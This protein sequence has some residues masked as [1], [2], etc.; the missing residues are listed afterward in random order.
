MKDDPK[1]WLFR[2]FNSP[3]FDTW[4]TI[5]YLYRYPNNG[6]QYYL[7]RKLK[8]LP[9][10]KRDYFEKCLPHLVHIM[11]SNSTKTKDLST[12]SCNSCG[13]TDSYSLS[14]FE[15]DDCFSKLVYKYDNP[16]N[17]TTETSRTND[18]VCNV[19]YNEPNNRVSLNSASNS[20][21]CCSISDICNNNVLFDDNIL[22]NKPKYCINCDFIYDYKYS[23]SLYDLLKDG[24]IEVYFMVKGASDEY[25]FICEVLC[26]EILQ[27]G[28]AL[29]YYDTK[30]LNKNIDSNLSNSVV[31]ESST[32]ENN[33]Y[34]KYASSFKDKN[35]RY[36]SSR[37]MKRSYSTDNY[38]ETAISQDTEINSIIY[39]NSL[40][41]L[42]N[43]AT[44]PCSETCSVKSDNTYLSSLFI[45]K[46]RSRPSSNNS[47]INAMVSDNAK[48]TEHIPDIDVSTNKCNLKKLTNER[49]T[50]NNFGSYKFED[51]RVNNNDIVCGID[52][53]NIKTNTTIS[54]QINNM[55]NISN[56]NNTN[57]INSINNINM[58]IKSVDYLRYYKNDLINILDKDDTKKTKLPIYCSY[59]LLTEPK[60]PSLP[61]K[62][63]SI[64]GIFTFFTRVVSGFFFDTTEL[65]N[66]ENIF[67]VPLYRKTAN[68]IFT[69]LPRDKNVESCKCDIVKDNNK[70]EFL[71]STQSSVNADSFNDNYFILKDDDNDLENRE[72]YY[73][74]KSIFDSNTSK[75]TLFNDISINNKSKKIQ[76]CN[77][78]NVNDIYL[79][80]SKVNICNDIDI[81]NDKFS[82][83]NV[84][85]DTE[86]NDVLNI[87][88]VANKDNKLKDFDSNNFSTDIIPTNNILPINETILDSNIKSNM[89]TSTFKGNQINELE[90]F[91]TPNKKSTKQGIDQQSKKCNQNIKS[92]PNN[93]KSHSSKKKIVKSKLIVIKDEGSSC[94][95][96]SSSTTNKNHE[97][98]KKSKYSMKYL[99]QGFIGS[100]NIKSSEN[101]SNFN[102]N[103][104]NNTNE[105]SDSTDNNAVLCSID[106]NSNPCINNDDSI[107][108]NNDNIDDNTVFN[109]ID[110][111]MIDGNLDNKKL[112][113]Y[114]NYKKSESNIDKNKI[115]TNIIIDNINDNGIGKKIDL[116]E[117]SRTDEFGLKSNIKVP[118]LSIS[119]IECNTDTPSIN[120]ISDI[121]C[122]KDDKDMSNNNKPVLIIKSTSVIQKPTDVKNET[123]DGVNTEFGNT[124]KND[125]NIK[126]TKLDNNIN[127]NTSNIN[128]NVTD[129]FN[130]Q[131]VDGNYENSKKVVTFSSDI[132]RFYPNVIEIEDSY[133]ILDENNKIIEPSDK[134]SLNSVDSKNNNITEVNT[135]SIESNKTND[136]SLDIE[137][138]EEMHNFKNNID[139]KII[140]EH[141]QPMECIEAKVYVENINNNIS[142]RKN[143]I[144]KFCNKECAMNISHNKICSD[145]NRSINDNIKENCNESNIDNV[146]IDNSND[147][148]IKDNK[149]INTN[150]I[151]DD[152]N[153]NNTGN[154]KKSS[155]N[156]YIRNTKEIEPENTKNNCSH[157]SKNTDSNNR[158]NKEHVN[159]HTNLKKNKKNYIQ[160]TDIIDKNNNADL[161]AGKIAL[162]IHSKNLI[163]TSE[164]NNRDINN[165]ST[166]NLM[167]SYIPISSVDEKNN[168]NV[169]DN[170]LLDSRSATDSIELSEENKVSISSINENKKIM[171]K[172]DDN[173]KLIIEN[174]ININ[175]IP[176]IDDINN[177]KF[178]SIIEKDNMKP[179]IILSKLEN[180][181]QTE[182]QKINKID[183]DSNIDSNLNLNNESQKLK[184]KTFVIENSDLSVNV[185]KK[186]QP[187]IIIEQFKNTQIPSFTKTHVDV[188]S[189]NHLKTRQKTH[190]KN[191]KMLYLNP[192]GDRKNYRSNKSSLLFR[193][194]L[195]KSSFK[196][197]LPSVLFLEELVTICKRLKTL[198]RPLRQRGL[199]IEIDLLN[200]NIQNSI[201]PIDIP[202]SQSTVVNIVKEYSAILDSA[203]N[204]P[205][206][207]VFETYDKNQICNTCKSKYYSNDIRNVKYI[208]NNIRDTGEYDNMTS[209]NCQNNNLNK[210]NNNAETNKI[211]NNLFN[212]EDPNQYNNIYLDHTCFRK[213]KKQ[214]SEIDNEF[215]LKNSPQNKEKD[216]I[217]TNFKNAAF[218]LH[219]LYSL[220]KDSTL[221]QNEVNAIKER[222]LNTLNQEKSQ[223]NRPNLTWPQKKELIRYNSIYKNYK[224]YKIIPAIIKRGNDLRQEILALQILNE[225]KSIFAEEDL[226]IKLFTYK[227]ILITNKSAFIECIENVES[228][229]TIKKKHT[230]IE[231]FKKV[232]AK[233]V[234]YDNGIDNFLCSL[235]GY[236]LAT[237]LLQIKDRHNG[238]ILIKDDG[239]LIHVDFG[240]ILGTHPG[241]YNV[242]RAPFKMSTEYLEIL[243]SKMDIFKS[244]F[245]E[246]FMA[247]RRNSDRLCRIIE[248]VS[249]NGYVSKKNIQAF[250]ERLKMDMGDGDVERYVEG[251][252]GWSINS[253]GTGLYDSYQ[254]FSHGYLK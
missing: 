235:V 23:F 232:I 169:L 48:S 137:N 84:C 4:L 86:N 97:N 39:K 92:K 252:I 68:T 119:T 43:Q 198:P 132:I 63:L 6:I 5:S 57:N 29:K 202:L 187:N 158:N 131:S 64:Q 15:T 77:K 72:S 34:D 236:S 35:D 22:A 160:N 122:N 49:E 171:L 69:S 93:N 20:N 44:N 181:Q 19:Y 241:F 244:T 249:V 151:K 126:N 75:I 65:V 90:E 76:M 176:N 190:E 91:L 128:Q 196:S 222:I 47:L 117:K 36:G 52:K 253:I 219:K 114:K 195:F 27:R 88:S 62:C 197:I 179:K 120:K 141:K 165:N 245:I 30:M 240:F 156:I 55:K 189:K 221:A 16:F 107:I 136:N 146:N 121:S 157:N 33:N 161:T 87:N 199:E 242:E 159:T 166:E 133:S 216:I 41:Y 100:K 96:N 163:I 224:G 226:H 81:N 85:N 186:N 98:K 178:L 104:I 206:Y 127:I 59:N 218:L 149:N 238:N 53:M 204:S 162:N 11:L 10:E 71:S 13:S 70:G 125:K 192:F 82:D 164:K 139:N 95:N 234:G 9:L 26:S 32:Y 147:D 135:D 174:D 14:C 144:N 58:S 243:G 46:R 215:S 203:E 200:Y 201:N 116:L 124:E 239:Q 101:A 112:N 150:N 56:I 182:I 1:L 78:I 193:G 212:D 229:H 207:V 191:I 67:Y 115:D 183:S 38:L 173:K 220:T 37:V 250:R 246:G 184:E 155:N 118:K 50:L 145:N 106:D 28:F 228:I 60:I 167:E 170:I 148:H 205:F 18:N 185:D 54:T 3:Y 208:C 225:M 223:Q 109:Y 213:L 108:D 12:T 103:S 25:G 94:E 123:F 45:D 233:K 154:V 168:I 80:P 110:N 214:P 227:I 66:Y 2:L 79:K 188:D 142:D 102:I 209:Q 217:N 8:Q 211:N 152:G 230:L 17:Y 172:N 138:K 248:I 143:N 111:N 254:Y 231:Y 83:I 61:R 51:L 175:T 130:V 42:G 24:G 40:D 251:L 105:N 74:N 7:C 99:F 31:P 180:N 153:K 247:L 134:M 140:H 194:L 210:S 21:E 177:N 89:T 113:S 73:N 237:Y 129:D